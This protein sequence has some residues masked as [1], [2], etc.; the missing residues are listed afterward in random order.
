M[1]REHS[2][3]RHAAIFLSGHRI[4]YTRQSL[5]QFYPGTPVHSRATTSRILGEG[6]EAA[7][8][9]N[10]FFKSIPISCYDLWG[11]TPK[12]ALHF[13]LLEGGWRERLKGKT[14]QNTAK[15]SQI[16]RSKNILCMKLTEIYNHCQEEYFVEMFWGLCCDIWVKQASFYQL[17]PD[18]GLLPYTGHV[19][20]GT[21]SQFTQEHFSTT[22]A[23]KQGAI[24]IQGVAMLF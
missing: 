9:H 5:Y 7:T 2:H 8:L 1:G 20:T 10:Q 4:N 6:K 21:I 11:V 23:K 15:Q 19:A 24:P 16:V 12:S 22:S 17:P 18:R 13:L 14:L 3:A